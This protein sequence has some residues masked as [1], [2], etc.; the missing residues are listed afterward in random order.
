[1]QRASV[2][3]P[4]F[5]IGLRQEHIE[6]FEKSIYIEPKYDPKSSSEYKIKNDSNDSTVFEVTGKK[7][8]TRPVR[9]FRDSTG[10]PLFEVERPFKILKTKNPWCVRLPGNHDEDLVDITMIGSWSLDKSS[11]FDLTFRNVLAKDTKTEEGRIVS[12][13]VQRQ[14]SVLGGFSVV[15]NGRKI[16]DI[17]ESM[18]RN[19]AIKRWAPHASRTS[20][21]HPSRVILDILVAGGVDLSLVRLSI[22]ITLNS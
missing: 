6:K 1:M 12:L 15:F 11:N 4:P 21:S 19:R 22:S 10:L 20:R 5:S 2:Q 16:A 17:R 9:E 3:E 18:E 7:Y 13:Q 14:N 8:S